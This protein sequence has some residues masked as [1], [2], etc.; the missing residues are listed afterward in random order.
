MT[1]SKSEDKRTAIMDAATH[2]IATSGI[3]VSTATIAKEAG[4]STGSLFTYFDSKAQLFS[5]LL[6][7]WLKRS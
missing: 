7:K 1:R 5:Q 2:S 6:I 3:Q 4:I